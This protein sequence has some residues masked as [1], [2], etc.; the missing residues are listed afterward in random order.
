MSKFSFL[1][2]LIE[3]LRIFESIFC[4]IKRIIP[5]SPSL[6]TLNV[7]IRFEEALKL[8]LALDECVRRI[9]LYKRSTKEGKKAAVNLV[10][11]ANT[12]RV[13]VGEYGKI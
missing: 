12:H 3:H 6:K 11:H 2:V 1:Y 10:I 5:P 4:T 9:N 8:N 7:L 13:T